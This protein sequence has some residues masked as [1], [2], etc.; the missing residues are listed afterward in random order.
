MQSLIS[1]PE[2]LLAKI[3]SDR[4]ISLDEAEHFT[5]PGYELADPF[6]FAQMEEAVLRIFSA[7]EAKEPIG[8]YADYDCDGIPAAVIL[9]DF[10]K[11]IGYQQFHLYIPDRHDEGYGLKES[12]IDE[13]LRAGVKLIITVDLGI[14]AHTQV[15]YASTLGI[16]VI[17]TDHHTPL[18][19]YPA[20]YAVI[21]PQHGEYPNK[22]ACGA[23]VAFHV[24]RAFLKK[25]STYFKVQPDWEK[26]LLDM[27]G[28]A[29]LSD[30]VPLVD[31][32]RV[33]AKYGLMVMQKSRRVGLQA[34]LRH[35]KIDQRNLT[36]DDLTFMVAPRLNAASRMDSPIH[37]F[38][39]LATDSFDEAQTLVAHLSTINDNR[40]TL[41]A[42][43][44]REA[45][46]KLKGR[47]LAS[48]I[49]VGDIAW[50]PPIL[51]LVASK[52]QEAHN[53][54]VFVWGQNGGDEIKGS[55]RADAKTDVARL[56]QTVPAET[57]LHFGGHR[58]AG[59]FSIA[60]DQVHFLEQVL[61]ETH[62][63]L[64]V[65][66]VKEKADPYDADFSVVN[67]KYT[68][69][70]ASCGPFGTGNPKPLFLFSNVTVQKIKLFGK[71]KEHLELTL[72]DAS[73]RTATAISFF[74]TVNDFETPLEE[75]TQ[76]SITGSLEEVKGYYG[77]GVR[78]RIEK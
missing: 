70:I 56:M 67:K 69:I 14:T 66:E 77:R 18:E 61:I 59:G 37:A 63:T 5:K 19:T 39:L 71:G 46:A 23:G 2:E 43:T 45:E 62:A 25:Y 53:K 44:M 42:Q 1:S 26:W 72:A 47:E 28:F 12:G 3:L 10:F 8:I 64:E 32:N 16:D 76:L 11:K 15:A 74:T 68:D 6:L 21:H 75:G 52:L 54:T 65:H 73:G 9:T 20:A 29:T 33:L 38:K 60:K 13:L 27:A 7:I 24:V 78:I 51:G 31:E 22:N 40:K 58:A 17:V 35:L 36:E 55:T 30:M 4:N 48:V 34:L 49:V 41:V 57:F 50:H